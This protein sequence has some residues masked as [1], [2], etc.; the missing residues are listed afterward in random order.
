MIGGTIVA[1]GAIVGVTLAVNNFTHMIDGNFRRLE[2]RIDSTSAQNVQT[3][4]ISKEVGRQIEAELKI[5]RDS[6][7]AVYRKLDRFELVDNR[8]TE[9]IAELIELYRNKAGLTKDQT[10]YFLD[11]LEKRFKI[12]PIPQPTQQDGDPWWYDY[13]GDP[14]AIPLDSVQ[15]QTYSLGH[16]K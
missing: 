8:Q 10:D 4:A 5:L 12:E 14:M 11:E 2:R 6:I 15:T 7:R 16:G 9:A 13:E 3:Q 1:V